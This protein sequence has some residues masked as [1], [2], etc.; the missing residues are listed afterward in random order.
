MV[1]KGACETGPAIHNF[2]PQKSHLRAWAAM[3]E[4]AVKSADLRGSFMQMAQQVETETRLGEQATNLKNLAKAVSIPSAD[5]RLL[6]EAVARCRAA[7][8]ATRKAV[9]IDLRGWAEE[10]LRLR[11]M[12][13]EINEAWAVVANAAGLLIDCEAAESVLAG[14]ASPSPDEL[15]ARYADHDNGWWHIDSLHRGLELRFAT[16]R[17]DVVAQLGQPAVAAVWGWLRRLASAFA[18][19]FEQSGQYN[20]ALPEL[21][22]HHRFWS[23]LA[24][25]ADLG[26]T[27]ILF[28]DALRIDLAEELLARL[29]QPGRQISSRLGLVSL[30]SRTLV[31]MASLLPRGGAGLAVVANNGALRC[32]IDDRDVSGP[33]GRTDQL[34]RMIPNIQVGELKK[35]TETQACA[36]GCG[37]EARRADD[38]GY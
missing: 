12:G 10:R 35:V 37:E 31:G 9:W 29:E 26:E 11:A 3:A 30:P 32:E 4:T 19:A 20:A 22:P 28:V 14:L 5:S 18:A 27:A 24:E 21:L 8:A 33:D 23:Q 2:L 36:V 17:A 34:C 6:E 7:T 15:I 38:S 16:C 1:H 25:T 13:L